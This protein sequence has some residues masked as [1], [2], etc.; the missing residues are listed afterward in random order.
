MW[1]ASFALDERGRL[2]VASR[3]TGDSQYG[4]A[5]AATPVCLY[6]HSLVEEDMD[7]SASECGTQVS[8]RSQIPTNIYPGIFTSTD[9]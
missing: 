3:E 1:G 9:S 7:F 4:E 2:Y 6:T 5:G 8:I